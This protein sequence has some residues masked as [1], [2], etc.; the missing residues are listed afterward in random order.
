MNLITKAYH[1]LYYCYYNLVSNKADHREDGASGLLTMFD[2][3]V[4]IATYYYLNVIIGRKIFVP[5]IEGFGIFFIG[6]LLARLNWI[7]FVRRKKYI[8]AVDDFK[9][10]PQYITV[11]IGVVLLILPFA[12]F[13][14]SGIKMGNYI[15][16]IH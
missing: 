6:V 16:S 5:A 10:L 7:Y 12:L 4:L 1:Y 15:R 8:E 13:V 14:F 2:V 9:G 3:S 11:A